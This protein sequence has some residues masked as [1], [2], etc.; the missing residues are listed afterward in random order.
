MLKRYEI[1]RKIFNSIMLNAIDI[2]Y[3]GFSND[4]VP[5]RFI[6]NKI[7]SFANV[8]MINNLIMRYATGLGMELPVNLERQPY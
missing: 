6:R 5:I 1:K 8:P 4:V 7:M 2:I 3:H